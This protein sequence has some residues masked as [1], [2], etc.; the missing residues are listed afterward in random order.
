M[1]KCIL[2]RL[3]EFMAV[4]IN[5]AETTAHTPAVGRTHGQHGV[6]ITLALP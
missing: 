5:L 6:P 1:T 4:L 3:K 2:P